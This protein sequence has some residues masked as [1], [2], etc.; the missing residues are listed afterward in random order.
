MKSKYKHVYYR[1]H[2]NN[3]KELNKKW[4]GQKSVRGV[5]KQKW[6]KTEREAAVY[7]DKLLISEGLEP[8]NIFVK[9]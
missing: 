3:L 9:K 5:V 2:N 4:T 8:V 6:F 7:I 1:K